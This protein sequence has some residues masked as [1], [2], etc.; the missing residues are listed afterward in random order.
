MEKLSVDELKNEL[1]QIS[2][3]SLLKWLL[4]ITLIYAFY[5][6]VY[7]H[8]DSR[9]LMLDLSDISSGL[10]PK[11]VLHLDIPLLIGV[12]FL[13][14][15]FDRKYV[16]SAL[17]IRTKMQI[18]WMIVG[19]VLFVLVIYMRMPSGMVE[20][21]EII[22][23][24]IVTALLEELAFRGVLFRWLEQA[25]LQWVSYMGSG[26]AW[27][28]LL[29]IRSLAVGGSSAIAAVVPMALMGI[30]VGAIYAFIY[31]KTNSLW[32]VVY[33]HGALSLL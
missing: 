14:V 20:G 4:F 8:A 15:L 7:L 13:C 11:V 22:H 28:A 25:K 3:K 19:V 18:L 30:V 29:S 12:V 10:I 32:L 27:G 17:A 5:D 2:K 23:A 33:L 1:K 24:L 26:L 16:V 21:Y 31:Q 9:R 6:A